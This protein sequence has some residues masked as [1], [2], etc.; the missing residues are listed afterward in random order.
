MEDGKEEKRSEEQQEAEP[1]QELLTKQREENLA[2]L[3]E[4]AITRE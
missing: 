1:Q 2:E 4:A 3:P